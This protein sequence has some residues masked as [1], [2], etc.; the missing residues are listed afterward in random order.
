MNGKI[1]F[2]A[3]LVL[4]LSVA[5]SP[6]RAQSVLSGR[7]L[8]DRQVPVKGASVYLDNTLD[9]ATSDS[10]GFFKF[11]TEEKG[12]QSLVVSALGYATTG[13]PLEISGDVSN[14]LFVLKGGDKSLDEVVISAGA[15]EASNE[16]DKTVL[17]A[18]D[19]VTTAGAQADVVRAIETLPGTQKQGAQ[20]GLFVR[21]GDASEALFIVDGMTVQNAFFSGPPGVATRSRFNAFQFKGV[22]FS[23]G[24][25][26]ARYGQALSSVLELSTIDLPDRSTINLGANLAGLYASGSKLWKNSGGEV[27]LN[28]LNVQPFY[29]MVKANVDYYR[30]P[31]G[32]SA[33]ARWAWKPSKDGLF[34]VSF[35]ANQFQAGIGVPDSIDRQIR[36]GIENKL[37]TTNANYRHNFSNKW[38]LYVAAAHSYN[39]DVIDY[40]GI[41]GKTVEQRLQGRLEVK[42]YINARMNLLMGAEWQHLEIQNVFARYE[43]KLREQ[44]IAYY[45]E[46]KWTPVYWISI[47]P[48]LRYERSQVLR[49]AGLAPRVSMAVRTSPHSQVSLAGG[50]F[51]QNP[52]LQYLYLSDPYPKNLHFQQAIHYIA[53]YQ[54][55]HRDRTLRIE[56]YYKDYR[57]LIREHGYGYNPASNRSVAA[58]LYS[59]PGAW[60]DNQG[61]GYAGGAELF[62][63]DKKTLKNT[64]YWISYSYIDTRRLYKNFLK[65]ATPDFVSTHNLNVIAKYWI[66]RWHTQINGTYSYGSGRP[67]YLPGSPGFLSD[68]TPDY[69]NLSVTV[70]YLRSF[71]KWFTVVY[72]GVDNIANTQNIFGYRF[73]PDGRRSVIRPPLYR[74]L[75][76]GV[77]MS[78]SAFD[79]DEL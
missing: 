60:I 45:A 63:R 11:S 57:R 69:Q 43:G 18:L 79:K 66:D 70:N 37:Y 19:I 2:K 36:F 76:V 10:A 40:S 5:A 62:W 14:I 50:L 17:K 32:G 34:K 68:R 15:F 47:Q 78:L 42:R 74:S 71:G 39:K 67:Y 4:M 77:N 44:Q 58:D 3:V 73:A 21:G 38:N 8:D 72:A 12:T 35:A 9:G 55:Q 48:G 53:N 75:F 6:L 33:S 49:D 7:V 65:E 13:K 52:D 61:T 59:H 28:Y 1:Y 16:K 54:Y 23:S 46:W 27:S 51:H 22:S 64:D 25:Y 20:N 31:E 24:G 29:A 30:A 41:A 26:S 56:G